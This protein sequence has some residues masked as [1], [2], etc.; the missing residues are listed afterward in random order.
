M[1]WIYRQS[2]GQLLR[3]AGTG[4]SGHGAGVNQ[5]DLQDVKMVGPIP[6]GR[7]TIG[8]AYS[9]SEKG[10]LVLPL[11]PAIDTDTLGR[12]GFLIH[13][14]LI[15]HVGENLASEGCIILSHDIRAQIA[16]SGDHDLLVEE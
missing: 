5:P 12:S 15:G 7:W 10:A 16:A 11:A 6:R 1:M 3:L 4:Y 9:S 13:G 8:P 14:D 2:T